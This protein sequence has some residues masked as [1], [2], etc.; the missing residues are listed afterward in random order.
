M[1][2]VED[3]TWPEKDSLRLLRSRPDRIGEYLRP[4]QPSAAL[5]GE[6]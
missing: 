4:R 3:W 6:V 2:K 5:Y 1:I